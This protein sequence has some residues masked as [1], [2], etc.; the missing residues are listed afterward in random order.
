MVASLVLFGLLQLALFCL[1]S[2]VDDRAHGLGCMLHEV[3]CVYQLA[4]WFAAVS[5]VLFGVQR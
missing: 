4:V 1:E 5:T 3:E 2:N